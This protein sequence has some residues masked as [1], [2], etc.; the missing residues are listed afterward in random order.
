MRGDYSTTVHPYARC[1]LCN[2]PFGVDDG[3]PLMLV[4][5]GILGPHSKDPSYLEFKS[6]GNS[7]DPIVYHDYCYLERMG[8][9]AAGLH[10]PLGCDCCGRSFRQLGYGFRTKLGLQDYQTGQ[11]H[12]EHFSGKFNE[13]I[14]CEECLLEGLGERNME[15]GRDLLVTGK[16]YHETKGMLVCTGP[17]AQ[18]IHKR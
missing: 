3:M 15:F 17:R 5:P 4:E 2:C 7:D 10:S 11:F 14:L 13:S 16:E 1:P 6:E 18:D 9:V 8:K 12:D